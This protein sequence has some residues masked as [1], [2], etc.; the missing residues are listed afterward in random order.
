MF[1]ERQKM[2]DADRFKDLEKR[3]RM[4]GAEPRTFF[5]KVWADHVIARLGD[6]AELLQV[7]RLVLHELSGSQ[8]VRALA[9]AGRQPV[10]RGQVFTVIEHLISTEPGRGPTDSR[11]EE[12]PHH[13]RDHAKGLARLGL[14]LHRLRRPAAGHRA[15]DGAGAG[16]RASRARRWSAA[17]ATPAP[18][19]ASARSPGASARR[20]AEHVLATQ[21]LAQVKPKTMRVSFDGAPPARGCMPKDMILALI[22]QD[23][24]AAAASATRSEFAGPVV[25]GPAGRRAADALQHVDRVRGPSTASC[26]RTR[27]RSSTSPAA[28]SRP[29]ARRGTAAVALLAH[30]ADRRRR[31]VR[32]RG[33][34]G[35]RRG[36]S[37]RSPGA[38]ARSRWLSIDA[39]VPD[40]AQA[41]RRRGAR[42]WPSARSTTCGSR[43]ARRSRA[44]PSTWP[45]SARAPTRACRTCAP[46]RR[47]CKGAR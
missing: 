16:H 10:S 15:R 33:D 9:E 44:S 23:R 47:C 27:R 4:N 21:T 5:D 41:S 8:A 37:R 17:T 22:G 46:P 45:T 18:S 19:A 26:R 36:S 6:D 34:G 29:R 14:P 30:A 31:R 11:L 1:A 42:R 32:P 13:D 3:I 43:P 12:R 28:S 24:R 35:L 7:D 20:E 38:S 40:P 2:L 39:R 25:R